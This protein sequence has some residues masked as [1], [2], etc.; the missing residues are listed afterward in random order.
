MGSIKCDDKIEH[1]QRDYSD[2][3]PKFVRDVLYAMNDLTANDLR[4]SKA[5][6]ILHSW[7]ADKCNYCA[8]VCPHAVI[9]PEIASAPDGY[10]SKKTK[11]SISGIN[12]SIQMAQIDC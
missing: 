4:V 9:R 6:S 10:I 5:T 8:L 7:N 11:P 2:K 3:T 12:Y 1:K